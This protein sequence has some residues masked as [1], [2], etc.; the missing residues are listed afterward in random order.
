MIYDKP[1]QILKIPDD[2]GTPIQG[3][4]QPVF[5]AYCAEMTVFHNRFWE[6]VQAGSRIDVMV[7]MPLR[8]KNADAGMFAEY[9]GHIYSIEQCQYQNDEN[10]LPVTVLSM[11]RTETQYDVAGV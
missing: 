2:A 11:K 3:K 9:D 5:D 10:G 8:R 1:I 4:L 7:E 6:S